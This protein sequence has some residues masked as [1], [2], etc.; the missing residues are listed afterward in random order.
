MAFSGTP[1]NDRED[2]GALDWTDNFP[3]QPSVGM[4]SGTNGKEKREFFLPLTKLQEGIAEE[5]AKA[6]PLKDTVGVAVKATGSITSNETNVNT[7]SFGTLTGISD[8]P[9]DDTTVKIGTVT[10]TFKTALTPTEGEVLIG[11]SLETALANLVSAIMHTGTP[12]T[13]YSCA[14]AN[15]LFTAVT[16]ATELTATAILRG[17]VGNGA[18]YE[19]LAGAG[20]NLT[21]SGAL[22]TGGVDDTITIDEKVY[23]FKGVLGT[24]EGNVLVGATAA[25][26][27]DNL[28][29][30]I[31]ST[32]V[33]EFQYCAAINPSVE[34]TTNTDTVQ[35]LSARTAGLAGNALAIETDATT[36]TLSGALLTGGIDEVGAKIK[37]QVISAMQATAVIDATDAPSV[38]TQLNAL[39]ATMRT[40]GLL[41]E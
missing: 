19:I 10:Y 40:V 25:D 37:T 1:I 11:I 32:V 8:A 39:L 14:A 36:F 26:S 15:T 4:G 28:K 6:D 7:P 33:T 21:A 23:T 3:V 12:D 18:T 5:I 35:T 17:T 31:N 27:L 2:R 16:T 38:I 20:S 34:A 13:D 29:L 22:A 24:T 41:A 9:A 30:A